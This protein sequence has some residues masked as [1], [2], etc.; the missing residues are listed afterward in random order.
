MLIYTF[1]SCK[2]EEDVESLWQQVSLLSRLRHENLQLFMGA[3]VH[4]VPCVI[5]SM[6]QGP[7]LYEKIHVRKEFLSRTYKISIARQ[8]TQAIGYLHAK[9]IAFSPAS[10]NSH[11]VILEAKVKLC[12]IDL[13]TAPSCP[14]VPCASTMGLISVFLRSP[15]QP[16][17]LAGSSSR[18]S[19]D[20]SSNSHDGNKISHK[21][22]ERESYFNRRQSPPNSP[23]LLGL[24]NDALDVIGRRSP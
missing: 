22:S 13:T 10:V 9:G 8:V 12:L 21:V 24:S 7:T 16:L 3:V 1:S 2:S 4:P 18:R 14:C 20:G 17:T 15:V 23:R 19:K 6:K 5:T 11:H